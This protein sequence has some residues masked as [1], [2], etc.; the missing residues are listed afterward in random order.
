MKFLIA[1]ILSIVSIIA[2]AEPFDAW[3]DTEKVLLVTSELALL[4]DYKSTSSVLYP[5][6]GYEEM[7]PILGKQP[8][9]D[10]LTAYFL[11]YMIGNYFIA[12]YLGH[13]SRVRWLLTLTVVESIAAG[14]N[15]SIGARI[16]F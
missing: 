16:N 7:N 2:Q 12:D 9:R 15:V 11:A 6:Q 14:H 4:A 10:R 8:G 13:D 3:T 5:N 1:I